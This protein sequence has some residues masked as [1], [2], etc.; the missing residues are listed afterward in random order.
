MTRCMLWMGPYVIGSQGLLWGHDIADPAEPA[1][2]TK[3]LFSEKIQRMTTLG[4]RNGDY[5]LL[6]QSASERCFF[7]K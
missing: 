7:P 3:Q 1:L 4:R 2:V 5:L 6:S